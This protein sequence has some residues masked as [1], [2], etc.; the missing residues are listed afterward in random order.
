[1]TIKIKT[2]ASRPEFLPVRGTIGASGFDLVSAEED[3][4][5]IA[6]GAIA[7]I[8]TGICIELPPGYEGQVRGRSG[9]SIRHGIVMNCIGTIDSDYRGEIKVM[10]TNISKTEY[11]VH[12]LDRIAQ[13]VVMMLPSV[14]LVSATEINSTA[15]GAG[16]F[17]STGR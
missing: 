3:D 6:P 4:I 7:L 1:M 11:T 14:Q 15:R 12:P 8:G 9:L 13:L 5:V 10:L 2:I 17:G 16:G